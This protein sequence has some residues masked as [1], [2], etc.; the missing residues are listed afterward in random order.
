[1]SVATVADLVEALRSTSLLSSQQVAEVEQLQAAHADPKQLAREL[2]Q[3]GWLT[4]LQ[5][6]LIVQGRARDLILGS[7]LLI[8]RLGEGGMGQ[9][10]KARHVQLDRV[11][12]LK[13][14]R[15]ENVQNQQAVQ[16]FQQEAKAAARLSH[17]NIVGLYELATVRGQTFLILEYVDGIDL[18]RLVEKR[19]LLPVSSACQYIQ[20]AALGL[21][22]AHEKGLIHRD[23]KPQ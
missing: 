13:F 19:G 2:V 9:V 3:R 8:E 23:L 22:H 12:A 1:M 16:R 14:L 5:A 6:G 7:Y 4:G 17:P 15:K 11:V 18:A 20:Q 21:Q 10:F